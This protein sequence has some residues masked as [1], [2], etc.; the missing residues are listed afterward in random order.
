MM[1]IDCAFLPEFINKW[2]LPRQVAVIIDVLRASTT[3]VTAITNGC[4]GVYPVASIA[5][6]LR[7]KQ[8]LHRLKPLLAG[9]RKGRKI[10]GFN[11]GNSPGEF[12][13]PV[14]AHRPIIITTTNGTKAIVRAKTA[15]LV[16]IGAFVN[17]SAVINLLQNS[18]DILLICSGQ[19]KRIACEDLAA[20]GAIIDRLLPT[21]KG[22]ILSDSAQIA[23][24][25]YQ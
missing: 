13:K 14:V 19:E 2:R 10:R 12:L 16:M 1:Q 5:E 6:A 3:I 17:L 20:A 25:I 23:H 4:R 15:K 8:R 11:L 18:T 24:L 7:Q 22:L 9:E 21:H